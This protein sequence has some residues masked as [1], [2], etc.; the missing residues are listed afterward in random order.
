MH[1]NSFFCPI[2]IRYVFSSTASLGL[3]L[4]GSHLMERSPPRPVKCSIAWCSWRHGG[5]A[6]RSARIGGGQMMKTMMN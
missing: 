3:A 6:A 5:L 1:P 4:R 2:G